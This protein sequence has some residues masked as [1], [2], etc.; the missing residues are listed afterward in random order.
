MDF[1]ASAA[2]LV[3][4]LGSSLR[5][6]SNDSLEA[7]PMRCKPDAPDVPVK[8]PSLP[9]WPCKAMIRLI[10]CCFSN[11]TPGPLNPSRSASPCISKFI[12]SCGVLADFALAA[13]CS[14]VALR[15]SFVF[16]AASSAAFAFVAAIDFSIFSDS[17]RNAKILDSIS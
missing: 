15:V 3:S 12:C 16:A 2:F 5:R 7:N 10:A 17:C 11:S 9:I 4:L 14:C 6:A 8:A 1:A 13:A